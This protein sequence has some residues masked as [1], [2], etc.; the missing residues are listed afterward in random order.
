MGHPLA[1]GRDVPGAEQMGLTMLTQNLKELTRRPNKQAPVTQTNG[2]APYV[3]V[4]NKGRW[5]SGDAIWVPLVFVS[6]FSWEKKK[7][8]RHHFRRKTLVKT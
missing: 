6:W 8:L 4:K 1:D 5:Y 2:N 7:R 3:Y